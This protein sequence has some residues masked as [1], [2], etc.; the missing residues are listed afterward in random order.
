MSGSRPGFEDPAAFREWRDG[1]LYR[2]LLRASRL[3][4]TTTLGRIH[5]RGFEDISLV[6]TNLL[7]NLDTEGSTITALAHRAGVTRQAASQQ[8]AALERLGYVERRASVTDGRAVVV[9]Q[10]PKGR[11]LLA[12]AVD[13]VVELEAGYGELLGEQRLD[14]LKALL[15]ELLDA[16]DPQG[17]LA[18]D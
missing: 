11:R 8:V 7:A 3:E 2:L 4:T 12:T 10:T 6:D 18:P 13:I 15:S 16:A 14:H 1:S 5:E 17:R 9:I